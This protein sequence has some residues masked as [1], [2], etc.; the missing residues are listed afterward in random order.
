MRRCC[1]RNSSATLFCCFDLFFCMPGRAMTLRGTGSSFSPFQAA[2]TRGR[3]LLF[4]GDLW[5]FTLFFV[6]SFAPLFPPITFTDVV[7]Q[8]KKQLHGAALA[9]DLVIGPREG[10]PVNRLFLF[11]P[12]FPRAGSTADAAGRN[13]RSGQPECRAVGKQLISSFSAPDLFGKK[14]SRHF[15]SE[16]K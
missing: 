16:E 5:N 7:F 8:N 3:G 14:R 15:V 4:T 2:I 1:C 9:P 13:G 11:W 10:K 6:V 12:F